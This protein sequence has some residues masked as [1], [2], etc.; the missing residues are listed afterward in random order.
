MSV[1]APLVMILAG[2]TGGHVY[3][4]LAVAEALRERGYRIAWLGTRGG[5]E[6]RVVP[7]AGFTLHCL[8]LRGVRGKHIGARLLALA[9]LVIALWQALRLVLRR[10]PGCVLGLGGYVAVPGGI[11]AWLLRKP[12]LIHEQNAVAGS[13]NRLLYPLATRVMSGFPAAFGAQRDSEPLG[14]PVRREILQLAA[15]EAVA[16][17]SPGSL[18]LLDV[19]ALQVDGTWNLFTQPIGALVFV[20]AAFAETNRLPFDMPEAETELVAGYHLE[21]SS[22][23]FAL[24]FAGEYTAMFVFS[25][26]VTVLFLGGWDVP[27]MSNATFEAMGNWGTL[28]GLA[29]FLAKSL[30]F[31]FFYVWVRFTIPRFRFDQLMHLGWKVLIPLGLANIVLTGFFQM[32]F[33][34]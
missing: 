15:E 21:Y 10:S 6:A 17:A 1:Q 9:A 28:V 26:L 7:A 11:A 5:L 3:P 29:S 4:A 2:G 20:I 14:N 32:A 33:G 27:F 22:M 8:P 23:K 12:L 31:M 19:V 34:D 24:F 18:R 16:T 25:T 30:A 13:A